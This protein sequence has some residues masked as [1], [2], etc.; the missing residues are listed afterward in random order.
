[1]TTDFGLS[2]LR[3]FCVAQSVPADA[4]NAGKSWSTLVPTLNERRSTAP[5]HIHRRRHHERRRR[6]ERY[7]GCMD[8]DDRGGH[9]GA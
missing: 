6:W 8:Y 1:L 9:E 5:R 4:E 3:S 7:M 2:T